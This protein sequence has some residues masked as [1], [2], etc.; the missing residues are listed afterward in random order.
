MEQRR[1]AE[2]D[3]V[4]DTRHHQGV[5][6]FTKPPKYVPLREILERRKQDLCLILL[7]EVQDPHNLG[8]I[9]R[10]AEA[11]DVDAVVI[12]KH[13]SVGITPAVHRTSMGGSSNVPIV[14]EN[15]YSV[16]KT[17][18]DEGVKTI[19][20]DSEGAVDYFDENLDGSI[21]LVVGG[22]D[23][24]LSASLIA[25]C[26]SVVRIPVKGRLSSLNVSVATAVILYER[27]RQQRKQETLKQ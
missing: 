7:D 3:R 8:A 10:T 9:L 17:L 12:S 5:I 19:G 13:R 6:A 22:E 15:L 16:L 18:K 2:L 20:V 24:G 26:D 1:R 21:A 11:T 14:R 23:K 25:K 4:S 27:M